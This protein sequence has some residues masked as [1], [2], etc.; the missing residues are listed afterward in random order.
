[1]GTVGRFSNLGIVVS[2]TPVT[3]ESDGGFSSEKCIL[4]MN[5]MLLHILKNISAYFLHHSY[6]CVKKLEALDCFFKPEP[7]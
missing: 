1:V 6:N 5:D 4:P 2:H 3:S 7:Q